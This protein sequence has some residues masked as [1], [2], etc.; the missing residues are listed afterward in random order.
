MTCLFL[1]KTLFMAQLIIHS[2]YIQSDGR[3]ENVVMDD[4]ECTEMAIWECVDVFC[5]IVL[6]CKL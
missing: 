1:K 2:L 5:S 6:K 4:T 3:Y